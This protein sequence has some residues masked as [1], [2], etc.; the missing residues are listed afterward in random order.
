MKHLITRSL[1]VVILTI[2][3]GACMRDIKKN[4]EQ[5]VHPIKKKSNMHFSNPQNTIHIENK[6][7]HSIADKGKIVSKNIVKDKGLNSNQKHKLTKNVPHGF[8]SPNRQIERIQ[9]E[10][11]SA[12]YED[13]S[14]SNEDD[15]VHNNNEGDS[16]IEIYPTGEEIILSKK[17]L[18]EKAKLI[19]DKKGQLGNKE[20]IALYKQAIK[21]DDTQ[22]VSV[23]VEYAEILIDDAQYNEA[24]RILEYG[25]KHHDNYKIFFLIGK[26]YDKLDEKKIAI[27]NYSKSIELNPNQQKVLYQR[28]LAYWNSGQNTKAKIDFKKIYDMKPDSFWGKHAN[29]YLH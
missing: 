28:A 12:P 29:K 17:T 14:T 2:C 3:L 7:V 6:A 27:E 15:S 19:I 26:A 5:A 20:A 16:K 9:Y 22:P 23:L 21:E 18:I 1:I 13:D 25:S 11:E 10:D 4:D 8:I 24:I